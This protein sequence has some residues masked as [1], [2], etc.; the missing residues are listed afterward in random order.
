M[1]TKYHGDPRNNTGSS[2]AYQGSRD[3]RQLPQHPV[4]KRQCAKKS[5]T[6]L[7]RNFQPNRS[8]QPDFDPDDGDTPEKR[9]RLS[10]TY[11]PRV[12]RYAS[13]YERERSPAVVNG[14]ER[15]RE[16]NYWRGNPPTYSEQ[17]REQSRSQGNPKYDCSVN[18][19]S[20]NSY[21]RYVERRNRADR[22]RSFQSSRS[23]Q[24]DGAD[25]PY[26]HN[27]E[28]RG[29][30]K[31]HEYP[32][33]GRSQERV[34]PW[35]DGTL[36]NRGNP[37]Y[38]RYSE[39]ANAKP[40]SHSK[41]PNPSGPNISNLK[42][43]KSEG[44]HP[45]TVHG[46]KRQVQPSVRKNRD[47]HR[48]SGIKDNP[49]SDTEKDGKHYMQPES[50]SA[51][52]VDV[53]EMEKRHSDPEPLDINNARMSSKPDAIFSSKTSIS[54]PNEI[55][56]VPETIECSNT[57]T[58]PNCKDSTISHS[59]EE[60]NIP[61]A[62]DVQGISTANA[63]PLSEPKNQCK[64]I[65]DKTEPSDAKGTSKSIAIQKEIATNGS[66]Q[67]NDQQDKSEVSC[68]TAIEE[69]Q[70]QPSKVTSS[71]ASESISKGKPNGPVQLVTEQLDAVSS[72][73]ESKQITLTLKNPQGNLN[74]VSDHAVAPGERKSE[75]TGPSLIQ[76]HDQVVLDQLDFETPDE[77]KSSPAR[78]QSSAKEMPS[79]ESEITLNEC[80]ST[81][82]PVPT[83]SQL[84]EMTSPPVKQDASDVSMNSFFRGGRLKLKS[85][86]DKVLSKSNPSLTKDEHS[87]LNKS[88]P[89]SPKSSGIDSEVD[90]KNQK[91]ESSKISTKS[92]HIL[93]ESNFT[94]QQNSSSILSGKDLLN[95]SVELKTASC[96][97]A[98]T[99]SPTENTIK[100]I[101][102]SVTNVRADSPVQES[103]H[104]EELKNTQTTERIEEPIDKHICDIEDVPM[105]DE[106]PNNLGEKAIHGILNDSIE[107]SG[108]DT[109]SGS[110]STNSALDAN[111]ALNSN[112]PTDIYNHSSQSNTRQSVDDRTKLHGISDEQSKFIVRNVITEPRPLDSVAVNQDTS[113]MDQ[114][115]PVSQ[116][117]G[118]SESTDVQTVSTVMKDVQAVLTDVQAVTKDVQSTS[119]DVQATLTDVQAVST[120]TKDVQATSTV[121]KD[122]QATSTVTKDVQATST[123]TKD[124]QATSTVTKDVQAT[125]T[126]VQAM[127]VD[128]IPQKD[129]GVS[130]EKTTD[131]NVSL[132]LSIIVF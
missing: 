112:L 22:D 65:S 26:L 102:P 11:A 66:C 34:P 68:S 123:V 77:C 111:E 85:I 88:T 69:E 93:E 17:Y 29:K 72:V 108:P 127:E 124:V 99:L 73:K 60:K 109:V 105:L 82:I 128:F 46:S 45:N 36:S 50:Y 116:A 49:T 37:R 90:L 113:V 7:V 115:L 51:K 101:N 130:S 126:D 5:T 39:E 80:S 91:S 16:R 84:D 24:Y 54:N 129:G 53:I 64:V 98:V 18:Q 100:E 6:Q 96:K 75:S 20:R 57:I 43:S 104:I 25:D 55:L 8:N 92:L 59:S 74:D 71:A 62:T 61:I 3:E 120:V 30:Y 125:S 122:V 14:E 117:I 97:D 15:S 86:L 63:L 27:V 89:S 40:A 35:R 107:T 131:H 33:R 119:T 12:G 41:D 121:T 23:H 114:S 52:S 132:L 44:A 4:P 87:V 118:N 10:E 81:I 47:N 110:L 76:A 31:K 79:E 1:N 42:Y 13:P 78:P 32:N 9:P 19:D 56:C 38:G 21:G 95:E 28:G 83:R 48:E 94:E 67:F 106:D 103:E 2:S 58:E 70:I